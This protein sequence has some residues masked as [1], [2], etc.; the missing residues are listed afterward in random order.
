MEEILILNLQIQT[1]NFMLI[2]EVIKY[3][4]RDNLVNYKQRPII[5]SGFSPH[6]ISYP[7]VIH[8]LSEIN[9]VKRMLNLYHDL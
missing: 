3:K 4:I 9:T 1:N 8:H 5:S 7:N 2:D 6:M